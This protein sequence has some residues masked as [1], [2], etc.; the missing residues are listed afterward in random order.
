MEWVDFFGGKPIKSVYRI[1][2]TVYV[3]NQRIDDGSG[4]ISTRVFTDIDT[5]MDQIIATIKSHDK[6]HNVNVVKKEI[7]DNKYYFDGL[8]EYFV[9]ECTLE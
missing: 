5:C 3:L 8:I 9:K 1:G 6:D 7:H 2:D 4:T